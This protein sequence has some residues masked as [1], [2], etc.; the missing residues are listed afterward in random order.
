MGSWDCENYICP[1]VT[2][3]ESIIITGHR[4][5]NSCEGVLRGRQLIISK[6]DPSTPSNISLEV[7]IKV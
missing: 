5:A 4:M 2:K 7:G 1:K 3:R 6:Y